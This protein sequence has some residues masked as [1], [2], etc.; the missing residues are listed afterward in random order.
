MNTSASGHPG[1][2]TPFI[3]RPVATTLFGVA[4][5]LAGWLAY[6]RLPVASLPEVDFP[7]IQV[8]TQLPGASPES[9][10]ELVTGPL[11]RTLGQIPGVATM[12]STSSFGISQITLQFVLERNIDAAAQD[13]Q[14]AIN[15]ASSA[16]PRTLPYPPV[17][18]KVNPADA[19]IVTLALTS[20]TLSLRQ[21][22]DAADTIIAQRL[23]MIA[24]VG[25]VTVEGGIRPAIRIQADL[26]RLSSYGISMAELRQ[27]IAAANVSGPK[28]VLDGRAQSYTI[29]SNDQITDAATY[30]S[31]VVAFRNG[32][33]VLLSDVA[34]VVDGLENRRVGSWY[35]GA[36][37]VIIHVQRQPG[38]NV[39]ETVRRLVEE[40]PRIQRAL[41]AGARI[42]LVH[43]RTE[44]IKASVRDVQFTLV[45]ATL[46]VVMVVLVFLRS[47]RATV[48]AG[49]ALPLS[50]V[51]TFAVMWLFGY[52]LN[53][54]SLM[55]LT[56]GTGF[57]VDDA[58]VMIENIVRHIEKGQ[59]PLRAA[60]DGAREIGFTIISLTASL[61][62]VFIPM[63]FMTGLV[64]RMF[65]EFAMTL[66]IAVIV[67]A[68]VSLT[69]TPM[70]C[71]RLLRP[72]HDDTRRDGPSHNSVYMRSL[73]FVLQHRLATLLVTIG[74]FALT[75]WMYIVV[76]KG[77]LPLQDTGM[78][79]AR[80]LAD[81]TS[82]HEEM[83]RLQAALSE[84]LRA[85]PAVKAVAA[86][87][88]VSQLN[89]TPNAAHFTITL[90]PR[91]S[92]DT[93]ITA[94]A[95]RLETQGR[96]IPGVNLYLQA[97]EGVPIRT[98]R[99]TVQY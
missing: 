72:S 77:F 8:M 17:Y 28:G 85:D 81:P 21:L 34:Q 48:I 42:E 86:S 97:V 75:T 2:S 12:T 47:A 38:A 14:S 35:Q 61:V 31:I 56:I 71:A 63:L 67:S 78:L 40:V 76:P 98:R 99:G 92:R 5:L 84:R 58:I 89:S 60:L 94:I 91:H 37:A 70:I 16:L 10:A 53:N 66:T 25:K 33:P 7:T 54:L 46:L 13:V 95:A 45:L 4:L 43:D 22:S 65:R 30:A 80:M 93:D 96:S 29:A 68:V 19:P 82:S 41:P 27:A 20:A 32:A 51:A 64:G 52:S 87:I 39:I 57:V 44:M 59:P 79:S 3:H 26:A 50:I 18:A 24:G 90:H 1:V 49:I 36:P 62:A 23:A 15:A 88:G 11:E 74:T 69:L 9:M 55:A 83:V 6:L 73:R